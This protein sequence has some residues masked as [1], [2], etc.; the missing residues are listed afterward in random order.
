MF[1]LNS[2]LK[3]LYP[4]I[5]GPSFAWK[6]VVFDFTEFMVKRGLLPEERVAFKEDRV[7]YHFPCHYLNTLK[8]GEEPRKML[9]SLGFK[10]TEEEE[11]PTCCG[12]CGIFSIKNPELSARLWEK[13]KKNIL[14][15]EATLI[16]TDC[17][18]CLFQMRAG[19]KKENQL[20]KIYHSAELYAK[21]LEQSLKQKTF[22]SSKSQMENKSE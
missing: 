4:E 2:I 1:D 13:K 6:D 10:P 15:S 17:P 14:R 12:F 20:F 21:V 19:L 16:A 22:P 8:L 11:P 7:F 18:G 5:L 9:Q 3:K